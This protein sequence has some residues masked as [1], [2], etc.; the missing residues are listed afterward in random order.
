M[1]TGITSPGIYDMSAAE[2][3]ADPCAPMSLSSSGARTI[4]K[5]CPALF[6]YRRENQENKNCFD[7]GSAGHLMVLEPKKFSEEVSIINADSY[8]MKAAKEERDAIREDGKIPLLA[9]EAEKLQAMREAIWCDPVARMAF[10]DGQPEKSLFWKDTEFGIWCR[11]RPDFIPSSGRYLVDY[12]TAASANPNDFMRSVM[13]YGYHQQAAW[14]L[15]GYHAVTGK[16]P[17]AFWF[18]VQMKEPPFLVSICRLDEQALLMG[19][20]LSRKAKGTFAWCLKNDS[21]PGYQPQVDEKA[22]VF[23]IA[24]PPWALREYE[25]KMELGSYEPPKFSEKEAA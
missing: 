16:R 13:S 4:I 1:S 19:E 6:K 8:R 3:H 10:D 7:F 24:P 14:Y 15:E 23:D 12:K 11:S 20:T 17:D 22:R 9:K 18:I 25:A 2:Y 5:E 21:W